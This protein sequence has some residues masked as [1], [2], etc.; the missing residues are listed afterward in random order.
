MKMQLFL[1][2][3][4][5]SNQTNLTKNPDTPKTCHPMQ[6]EETIRMLSIVT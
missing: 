3:P 1:N 5:G 4:I 2:T 6:M